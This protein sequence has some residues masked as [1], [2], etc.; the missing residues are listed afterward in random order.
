M[1][2]DEGFKFVWDMVL[3]WVMVIYKMV[4]VNFDIF[5]FVINLGDVK[6]IIDEGKK[7]VYI[8]MENV[9]LLGED[10]SFLEIFY[11]MGLRMVGFVYFKNN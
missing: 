6:V 1:V 2:I 7:I 4:E 10:L 11:K 9:Y 3:L 5:V 8:S